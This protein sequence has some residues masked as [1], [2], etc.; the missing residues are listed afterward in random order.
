MNFSFR[1]AARLVTM[2]AATALASAEAM[3]QTSTD[4]LEQPAADSWKFTLGLGVGSGPKYPGSSERKTRALPIFSANYGR[5]FIGGTPNAGAPVGL[6]AYLY[7]DNHWRLGAGLG[8]NLEKPRKESDS[9][10]LRGLGDI[11]ATA[12]GSIFASYSDKWF[13]V[14]GSVV[15]DVGGKHEGTRASLGFDAKYA[16]TDKLLLSAGPGLTWADRKY[17]QTFFGI[18]AAQSANSGLPVYTAKSGLNS[19]RFTVGA[20]YRLTPN[21]S[22]GTRFTAEDLRGDAADS[23]ITQK[24]AQNSFSLFAAYRF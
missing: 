19:I 2:T 4:S 12:L 10:S 13:S 3:A 7:Q 21:W 9:P 18:D 24:K 15:T 6:G 16:L 22:L 17:T 1:S 20:D 5:Y 8:G 14:R 11:D 23:P